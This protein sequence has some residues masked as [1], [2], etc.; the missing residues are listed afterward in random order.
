MGKSCCGVNGEIPAWR[1][2]GNPAAAHGS[3]Y[4]DDFVA[5]RSPIN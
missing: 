3:M 5:I 4:F 1:E 2:W